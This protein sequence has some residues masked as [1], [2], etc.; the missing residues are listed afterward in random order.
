[1]CGEGSEKHPNQIIILSDVGTEVESEYPTDGQTNE[2]EWLSE[3]FDMI[4]RN[5]IFLFTDQ[6]GKKIKQ[7]NERANERTKRHKG[8]ITHESV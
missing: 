3:K 5:E 8:N 2:C 4:T 1:M 7:T 6:Q